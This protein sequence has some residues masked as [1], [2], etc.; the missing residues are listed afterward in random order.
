MCMLGVDADILVYQAAGAAQHTFYEVYPLSEATKEEPDERL[1]IERFASAKGR[2]AWL[3]KHGKTKKDFGVFAVLEYQEDFQAL[4]ICDTMIAGMIKNVGATSAMFF[5]SDDKNFRHRL[6][7]TT[8]Y[9]VRDQEKPKHYHL[10]KQHLITKYNAIVL[11]DMEADDALGIL[12]QLCDDDGV[13]YVLAT[14]DKDLKQIPGQH[15]HITSKKLF[16]VSVKESLDHFFTQVLTGDRT[17]SIPGLPGMGAKT[18]EKV[19]SS[20]QSVEDYLNACKETYTEVLKTKSPVLNKVELH[21]D[22]PITYLNEQANLLFIRRDP[23]IG[24]IIK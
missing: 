21:V 9:K 22:D 12:S 16:H 10:I 20:C 24:V 23:N 17:D 7:V 5:L 3:K 1:L 15:Y 8:P 18:A 14:D 19:L 6:A 11:Q 4:L 13:P 2:D